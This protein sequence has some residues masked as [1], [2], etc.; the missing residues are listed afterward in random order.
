MSS[1][2]IASF[3]ILAFSVGI[4]L[5]ANITDKQAHQNH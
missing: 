4:A 5:Y 3:F 2:T 1:L